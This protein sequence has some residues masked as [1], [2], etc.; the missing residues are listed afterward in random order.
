MSNALS[1]PEALYDMELDDLLEQST[2]KPP[3]ASA[4]VPVILDELQDLLDESLALKQEEAAIKFLREKQKRGGGT[5]QERAEDE[6]RIREWE[7]RREWDTKANV[8]VFEVRECSCGTVET[9]YSHL[10]HWQQHKEKRISRSVRA[11]QQIAALPNM[12]AKQQVKVDCCSKCAE[13]KGWDLK[14]EA[15]FMWSF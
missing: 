12:I 14:G 7:A 1:E 6:A 13:L 11:H 2:A 4:P 3:K 10:M 8:A 5:A 9:I 15:T